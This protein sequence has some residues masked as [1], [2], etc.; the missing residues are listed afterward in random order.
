MKTAHY[1]HV[2]AHF[3][4]PMLALAVKETFQRVR[5]VLRAQARRLPSSGTQ[6]RRH[7]ATVLAQRQGFVRALPECHARA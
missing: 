5:V 3:I 6:E 2:K 7:R 1:P 4:E